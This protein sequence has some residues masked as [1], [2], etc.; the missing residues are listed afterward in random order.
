VQRQ[1]VLTNLCL[2]ECELVTDQRVQAMAE[3][4]ALTEL[5]LGECELVTYTRNTC[6]FEFTLDFFNFTQHK[7]LEEPALAFHGE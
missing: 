7:P 5:N 6:S 4:T 1:S 2:G 3:L